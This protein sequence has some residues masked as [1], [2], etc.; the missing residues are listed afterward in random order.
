M[1][2]VWWLSNLRSWGGEPIRIAILNWRDTQHPRAGGSE[3]LVHQQALELNNRGHLVT[4][5]SSSL[6]RGASPGRPTEYEVIRTGGRFTVY[7]RV[8]RRVIREIEERKV[9][10]ILEHVN[11]VPWFSPL[12]SRIPS[13]AFLYHVVGRTF[14]QEL[15]FPLALLGYTAERY[16]PLFYRGVPCAC[17]GPSALTE[18]CGLGFDREQLSIAEPGVD[19]RVFR[20]SQYKSAFPSF[21]MIG[22]LK[23]YKHH[24]HAIRALKV[25]LQTVPDAVLN[26]VGAS[27][28]GIS[29]H[30]QALSK[31]L[32]VHRSVR[33]F[34]HVD[35]ELKVELMQT[36]W[37]LVYTSEREGWGLGVLEAAACGTPSIVPAV[38]GLM[39]AVV[40]GKTGLVFPW[41]DYL[42]LA[43][44]MITLSSR[45]GLLEEL[46]KSSLERASA[47]TWKRHGSFI[48]RLLD[49][50]VAKR[51]RET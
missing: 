46:G 34:G 24:D 48:E 38:G 15:P 39:D 17:L 10:V 26:I 29:E 20:P 50:A 3:H 43:H 27:Q 41:G 7:P 42:T 4:L 5:F 51:R 47:F 25:V 31:T 35:D 44:H 14:F 40:P 18:Y 33:F 32:G 36:S 21:L 9:D 1:P 19:A 11:G 30:L 16:S 28:G 8:S 6:P 22:P 13:A 2:R 12:W 23:T 45:S 37:A 49:T